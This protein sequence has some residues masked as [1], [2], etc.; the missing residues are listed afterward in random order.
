M[1]LRDNGLADVADTI[2]ATAGELPEEVDSA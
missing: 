2:E 1:M